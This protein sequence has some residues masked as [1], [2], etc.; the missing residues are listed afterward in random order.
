MYSKSQKPVNLYSRVQKKRLDS[1]TSYGVIN[2]KTYKVFI[3]LNSPQAAY[4]NTF[5]FFDYDQPNQ[6]VL[7]GLE[8]NE[9]ITQILF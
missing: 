9:F 1:A 8:K 3:E 4:L 5:T 2:T 6:Y 7:I